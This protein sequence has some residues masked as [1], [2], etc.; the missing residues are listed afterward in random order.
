MIY[1]LEVMAVEWVALFMKFDRKIAEA[2]VGGE[3]GLVQEKK[4]RT[5]GRR[6]LEL[7]LSRSPQR[8]NQLV[9]KY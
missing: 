7:G 5:K 3:R 6:T 1:Y 9:F 4:R 8:A 2:E